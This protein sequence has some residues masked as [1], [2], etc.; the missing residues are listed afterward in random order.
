ML[1][2]SSVVTEDEGVARS[3]PP[4]SPLID[5]DAKAAYS[6]HGRKVD[7][8]RHRG[9]LL[10]VAAVTSAALWFGWV[11]WRTLSDEHNLWHAIATQRASMVGPAVLIVVAAIF[12]AERRWPAV[13]RPMLARA[14]LVDAGYLAVFAVIVAPLVTLIDTGFAVN[15]QRQA[16]FLIVGRLPVVPQVA[17]VVAILVGMDA[18]NWLAHGASH[19]FG[20]LWRLHALHHSQEDMSVFTTFRTHPLVHAS[21]LPAIVPALV[22][23]A[24]G[25]VPTS[26][27][28]AYGCFVAL[29]HANL[30]W[31]FGPLGRVLVSPAYHR[32]HH[33]RTPLDA[34]GTVNFGFVLVCWDRLAR[35]A[36]L[37]RGG[38]PVVTGI[39]GRPVPIEQTGGPLRATGVIAAQLLQPFG[40]RA[41]M[42]GPP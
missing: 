13:P 11:G 29:A 5:R 3:A 38:E 32:L 37:P 35:R 18:M 15:A 30:P 39:A 24:S 31:T 40:T 14:H 17:S 25:P 41:A 20:G 26:A 22:L 19:R 42:D 16:Q 21:Y 12:L 2:E 8:P 1:G 7:G 34:R 9:A 33:A 36:V 6:D 23:G 10:G 28:V 4:R 27:L